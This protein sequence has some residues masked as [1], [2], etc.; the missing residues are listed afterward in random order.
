M[1]TILEIAADRYGA[2]PG[3]ADPIALIWAAERASRVIGVDATKD[4]IR[5]LNA[6]RR[7]FGKIPVRFEYG[8]PL[9]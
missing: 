4:G 2:G 5:K 8:H 9:F 6:Q 7:K 3:I 1:E